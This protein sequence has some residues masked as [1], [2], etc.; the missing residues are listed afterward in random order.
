MTHV[1]KGVILAQVKINIQ[2]LNLYMHSIK[3]YIRD[4][5]RKNLWF[6]FRS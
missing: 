5:D 6:L 4:L 3:N 2:P 1:K